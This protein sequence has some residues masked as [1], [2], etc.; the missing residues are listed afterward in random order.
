MRD[1]RHQGEFLG[2]AP[3]GRE[4]IW[5]ETHVGRFEHGKLVEHWGDS[6]DLGLMQQI[7]AV[8][9]MGEQEVEPSH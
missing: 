2:V 1:S 5:T 8:L 7:G 6:D 3:T 9:E 4:V